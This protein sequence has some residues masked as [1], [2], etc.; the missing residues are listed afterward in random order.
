MGRD[1]RQQGNFSCVASRNTR[2]GL[3]TTAGCTVLV[4][5]MEGRTKLLLVLVLL[6]ILVLDLQE[7]LGIHHT[8]HNPGPSQEHIQQA[9]DTLRAEEDILK[10]VQVSLKLLE[11]IL[12]VQLILKEVLAIH[13]HLGVIHKVVEAILK[14]AEAIL[15]VVE[16]TH[17]AVEDIHKVV[18]AILKLVEAIPKVV[19][20]TLKALLL[21]LCIPKVTF[22]L[23]QLVD[24]SILTHKVQYILQPLFKGYLI[25]VLK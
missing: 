13:N 14:V 23:D 15:K 1:R 20:F 4:V 19:A 5:A 2:V 18:E 21:I 17:R 25:V 22:L 12:K 3:I 8:L 6:G 10:Q 11:V 7:E 24:S 9:Q 16:V